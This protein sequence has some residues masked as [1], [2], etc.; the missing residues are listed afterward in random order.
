MYINHDFK[1][2]LSNFTNNYEIVVIKSTINRITSDI[3]QLKAVPQ[4]VK[5]ENI[6]Q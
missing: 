6:I 2:F 4:Y 5:K 1:T 3:A